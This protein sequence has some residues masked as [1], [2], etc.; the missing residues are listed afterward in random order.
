MTF[1][2][3]PACAQKAAL[4][5]VYRFPFLAADDTCKGIVDALQSLHGTA[6]ISGIRS[7]PVDAVLLRCS[8]AL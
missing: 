1:G 7:L 8:R 3:K 6:E 5:G 4:A 2:V